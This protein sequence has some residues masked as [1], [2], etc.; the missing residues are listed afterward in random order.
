M[1]N[2]SEMCPEWW[3]NVQ[4]FNSVY[5]TKNCVCTW[6]NSRVIPFNVLFVKR[7]RLSLH[8]Y[9]WS[10]VENRWNLMKNTH[11]INLL[12]NPFSQMSW[13]L[14]RWQLNGYA[15]YMFDI[16]WKSRQW[17]GVC[18]RKPLETKPVFVRNT[19]R[20]S[21]RWQF[22]HTPSK[23]SFRFKTWQ[24]GKGLACKQRCVIVSSI[25]CT[26]Q[27][28]IQKHGQFNLVCSHC[29][30]KLSRAWNASFT[31]HEMRPRH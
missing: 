6:E 19:F 26:L 14:K 5:K 23:A 28:W 11:P 24:K 2:E 10:I 12:C 22:F 9:K 15:H 27:H 1:E 7:W 4:L 30:V 8:C 17:A 18:H 3:Y 29:L 16:A 25:R 21:E 13:L 31:T 20:P